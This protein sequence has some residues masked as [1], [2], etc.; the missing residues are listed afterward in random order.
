MKCIEL[1]LA[2]KLFE[3]METPGTR[4]GIFSSL[5]S[6]TEHIVGYLT[7]F[8]TNHLRSRTTFSGGEFRHFLPGVY[9]KN[10]LI[11]PKSKELRL[12]GLAMGAILPHKAITIGTNPCIG[13]FEMR[14]GGLFMGKHSRSRKNAKERDGLEWYL[15]YRHFPAGNSEVTPEDC[16]VVWSPDT[17]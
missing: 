7:F 13:I 9:E 17:F 12:R 2:A 16:L 14:V 5:T 1:S 15:Q 11:R 4:R 6:L 3:G 8:G 10:V